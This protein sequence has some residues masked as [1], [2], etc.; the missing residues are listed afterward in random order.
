MAADHGWRDATLRGAIG[1]ADRRTGL[2]TRA[3]AARAAA[4]G[5]PMSVRKVASLIL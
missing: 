5:D 3:C 1:G 2:D 4:K